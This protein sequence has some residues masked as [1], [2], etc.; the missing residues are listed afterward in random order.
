MV[1]PWPGDVGR[2]RFLGWRGI[3]LGFFVIGVL[4]FSEFINEFSICFVDDCRDGFVA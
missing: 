3:V 2:P 4:S 1:G